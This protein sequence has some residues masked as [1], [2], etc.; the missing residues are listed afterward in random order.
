MILSSRRSQKVRSDDE[1]DIR[2]LS[3]RQT[4]QNIAGAQG[5][6]G[7][8]SNTSSKA[9]S[10]DAAKDV[11]SGVAAI[12]L[13][14]PS[15]TKTKSKNIDVLEEFKKSNAKNAANF[16]VIGQPIS[17]FH[18]LCNANTPRPR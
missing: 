4:N 17:T 1:E 2:L 11:M 5:K 9:A 10:K 14:E 16:V 13:E 3:G 8:V 7:A 18:L 6:K 12:Q 15:Q